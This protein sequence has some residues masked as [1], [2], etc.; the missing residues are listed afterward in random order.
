MHRVGFCHCC[1]NSELI[2]LIVRHLGCLRDTFSSLVTTCCIPGCS[3]TVMK[4]FILRLLGER[5]VG[6]LV[7][8]DLEKVDKNKTR[9]R[10]SVLVL[11]SLKYF[12][13]V[14]YYFLFFYWNL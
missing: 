14:F 3:V 4:T 6:S 2:V 10:F 8:R 5:S 1:T 9:T 13:V 7:L 12:K 11:K